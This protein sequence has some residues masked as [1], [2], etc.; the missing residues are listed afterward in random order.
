M[1]TN[2][3]QNKDFIRTIFLKMVFLFAAVVYV[4]I[5]NSYQE[6]FS[7]TDFESAASVEETRKK[8]KNLPKTDIWWNVY[9]KDQAWYFKNVNLIHPTALIHRY[10]DISELT[11]IPK[12]EISKFKVNSPLGRMEFIQF[13]N[14]PQSLTTSVVILQNG[15]IVFEYYRDQQPYEKTIYWS[16]TKIIVSMLVGILEDRGLI[17][18]DDPVGLHI[19]DLKNSAYGDITIENLMNMSSG[20]DCPDNYFD[21]ETCYYEYSSAIGDGYWTEESPENPYIFVATLTPEKSS[22]QGET[23]QYSGVNTFILGWLVEE[24]FNSPL[25]NVISKEIWM[26]IGA[27]ADGL[28]LAP[29]FGVPIMHGGLIARSRDAARVG[30][31]FTP[32]YGVVSKEKLVSDAFITSIKRPTSFM[33]KESVPYIQTTKESSYPRYHW[34]SVF[35]NGDFFK[36]GW[37]GQGFLVN[38]DKDIVAIYTGYAKDA[39]E[40]QPNF[41]P[42]L[43]QV[44]RHVLSD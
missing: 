41:L 27:E 8:L 2:Q 34:D 11:S 7:S 18:F 4:P 26:K 14:N 12:P 42:I 28:M 22:R 6:S 5:C 19:N 10:G 16:V 1:F 38:P 21:K 20:L 23:Y 25:Q 24:K 30:L 35:S 13:L 31:L 29:R 9:G 36:G 43:R 33:R 15:K 17:N 3:N 32:S 40:S 44:L 37:A 39:N